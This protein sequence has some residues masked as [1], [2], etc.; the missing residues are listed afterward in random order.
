[1]ASTG[2]VA[3]FGNDIHEA[4]WTALLSVNGMK[5]PRPNSGFLLGGDISRPEMITVASN[6]INLG[7]KLYTHCKCHTSVCLYCI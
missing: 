5:L 7:F 2:E 1:M 6:L 3:A 4:Y